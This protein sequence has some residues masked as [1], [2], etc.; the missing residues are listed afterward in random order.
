MAYFNAEGFFIKCLYAAFCIGVRSCPWAF[1]K[2]C[3]KFV[4]F[5]P[6]SELENDENV[7]ELSAALY[8]EGED[9][10]GELTEI[11]EDSDW[12]EVEDAIQQFEDQ[13]SDE[14]ECDHDCECEEDEEC[15]GGCCCHHHHE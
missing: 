10:N 4:I 13:Y 8:T 12:E 15:E 3:K 9:G 11:T 7:I 14:C 5:Y 6:I 1:W 2:L